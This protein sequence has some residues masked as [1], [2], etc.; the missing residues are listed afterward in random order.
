MVFEVAF[1]TYT[2]SDL[3]YHTHKHK[4]KHE[5]KRKY[6]NLYRCYVANV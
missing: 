2:D 1:Y 6:R 3:L 5:K 4:R